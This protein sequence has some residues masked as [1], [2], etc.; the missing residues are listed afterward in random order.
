[1][2]IVMNIDE[3]DNERQFNNLGEYKSEIILFKF[4]ATADLNDQ[5]LYFYYL[6]FYFYFWPQ[7]NF[8]KFEILYF[9]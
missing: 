5:C 7:A 6:Y 2:Q 3:F 4:L 9:H 8:Y 1:M